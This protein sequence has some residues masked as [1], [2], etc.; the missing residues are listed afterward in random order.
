MAILHRIYMCPYEYFYS[1]SI[2]FAIFHVILDSVIGLANTVCLKLSNTGTP[3][4][5]RKT[6][7]CLKPVQQHS[8]YKSNVMFV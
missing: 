4:E 8:K 5:A 7:N 2:D 6:V 1:V 3:K